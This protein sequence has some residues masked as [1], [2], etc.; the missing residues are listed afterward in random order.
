MRAPPVIHVPIRNYVQNHVL[1]GLICL[2]QAL[3]HV[4]VVT[5]N[6]H[7]KQDYSN[8]DHVFKRKQLT[9]PKDNAFLCIAVQELNT[10]QS[11]KKNWYL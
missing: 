10:I 3:L 6:V 9:V 7:P 4:T 8:V 1:Q 2:T 11:N 5:E